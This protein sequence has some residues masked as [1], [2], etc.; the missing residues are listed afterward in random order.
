M[1]TSPNLPNCAPYSDCAARCLTQDFC[2]TL[3]Q[4]PTDLFEATSRGD[5]ARCQ[6]LLATCKAHASASGMALFERYMVHL[7]AALDSDLWDY[8]LECKSKELHDWIETTAEALHCQ[9]PAPCGCASQA[10]REAA[11]VQMPRS[12]TISG[13]ASQK[14]VHSREPCPL[15]SHP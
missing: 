11:V 4:L 6:A 14:F 9:L 1:Q 5:L 2:S 10:A 3:T 12:Q 15:N 8:I 7:E 13:E